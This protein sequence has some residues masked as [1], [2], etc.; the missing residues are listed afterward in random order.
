[1]LC[2]AHVQPIGQRG[3]HA[4][5]S[6]VSPA[7]TSFSSFSIPF[8]VATTARTRLYLR[9]PLQRTWQTCIDVVSLV[10]AVAAAQLLP[11]PQC[12]VRLTHPPWART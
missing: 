2:L 12:R 4:I 11:R 3:R 9:G 6:L 7:S 1:M 5:G 10:Q 8:S